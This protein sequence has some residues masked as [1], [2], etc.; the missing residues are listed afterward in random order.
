MATEAKP[1]VRATKDAVQVEQA[2]RPGGQT[3]VQ[4]MTYRWPDLEPQRLVHYS[5][6]LLQMP[7][8]H[9]IL[10]RAV[11]YEGDSTRQGSANTK[12]RDDVHGSHRKLYAQ[13][14]SGRA[15]A[16][17]KMSPV[18]RG[19]GVAFGPHPRDFST[20]LPRKIYDQAWR[21]ALSH[22]LSRGELIVV[23]NEIE[24]NE[25]STPFFIKHL[26][27][28]HG[29]H[30]KGRSTFITLKPNEMLSD[31]VE[32]FHNQ[33][34]TISVEDLDVKN[35]LETARLVIEKNALHRILLSHTTDLAKVDTLFSPSADGKRVYPLDFSR[36]ASTWK[37]A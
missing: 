3:P 31:A 2:Q 26:L 22:R 9:D 19:G 13:K 5:R 10:H 21:I 4:V 1:N 16:G 29:W 18:R 7:V 11:I 33:A 25:E 17:D 23:D 34:R 32:K 12:W 27:Q 30:G 35:V 6:R 20:D 8:R 28:A 24:M 14:G 37:N 15:R 36:M